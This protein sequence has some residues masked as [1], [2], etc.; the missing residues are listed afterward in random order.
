V[1]APIFIISGVPG[2]GKSSV[3]RA[4]MGRFP[5]SIHLPVDS[6]RSWVVQGYADPTK[7]WDDETDLQF[8]LARSS[9][10]EMARRYNDEG[11]AVAIDEVLWPHEVEDIVA[12]SLSGRHLYRIVL[13][14][15]IEV[16]LHRNAT[17]TNKRF[18]TA[19]LE[20]TI[21]MLHKRLDP[22]AE[23]WADWLVLNTADMTIGETV[24]AILAYSSF[25]AT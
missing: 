18:D 6:I 13:H 4:L 19:V 22:A 17:R 20:D 7:P 25:A 24:D 11:F 12:P 8:R 16:T 21:R 5:R 9:A 3:A 23:G 10:A 14:A 1:T 2:T 15:P